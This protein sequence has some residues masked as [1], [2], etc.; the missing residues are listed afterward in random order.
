MK[1]NCIIRGLLA[2]AMVLIPFHRCMAETPDLATVKFHYE[3]Q[4]AVLH[5][6]EMAD[7]AEMAGKYTNAL[8]T[9]KLQGQQAG[10]LDKVTF[11]LAELQR[12]TKSG[13]PPESSKD[14]GPEFA[15][16][17]DAMNQNLRMLGTRTAK[18]VIRLAS[19]YDRQ[20]GDMQ[21][22][23]T[24]GGQIEQA[25]AVRKERKELESSSEIAEAKSALAE[26]AKA[27]TPNNG[28]A[29][30]GTTNMG[31]DSANPVTASANPV[32]PNA[33]VETVAPAGT[34]AADIE[35]RLVGTRWPLPGITDGPA[36]RRYIELSTNGLLKRAWIKDKPD[37]KFQWK[38][39]PDGTV[40]LHTGLNQSLVSTLSLSP[41]LS[42]GYLVRDNGI[43]A[44]IRRRAG[45]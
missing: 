18:E 33:N 36:D 25:L 38:V 8:N 34:K 12:F 37:V 5:T 1:R 7:R 11:A 13:R 24:K 9:L 14:A 6:Q 32:R 22:E 21:T 39:R 4:I 28:P 26:P 3:S 31:T 2:S 44:T 15:K 20:L 30:A 10:D 43:K 29:K 16:L 19:D 17:F 42:E 23:L 35:R 27:G 40:E 45:E 41:D